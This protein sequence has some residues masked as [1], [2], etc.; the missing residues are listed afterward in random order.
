MKISKQVAGPILKNLLGEK[1]VF[2]G[3]G[4]EIAESQGFMYMDH[5]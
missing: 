1:K 2:L 5:S 3:G 4:T